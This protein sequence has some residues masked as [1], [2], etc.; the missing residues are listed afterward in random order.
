MSLLSAKYIC[1]RCGKKFEQSSMYPATKIP[2]IRVATEA[3]YRVIKSP[4]LC[5]NCRRSFIHT[6]ENWWVF[7]Q[8]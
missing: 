2:K 3:G 4:L 5:Q 1:E 6:V 7:N 8:K